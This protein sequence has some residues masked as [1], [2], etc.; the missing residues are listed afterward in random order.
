MEPNSF[1][2]CLVRILFGAGMLDRLGSESAMIGH[3]ALIVTGRSSARKTGLLDKV[4]TMLGASGVTSVVYDKIPENPLTSHAHEGA[5]LVRETGCD[6]VLGVGGGSALDAAK[7]IAFAVKNPG[8]ISDYIFGKPGQ[9]ALPI[10]AVPT[11]AGTGSE[12]DSLAV[13]TNPETCD[14]KSLKSPFVYPALAIVD[15]DLLHTLPIPLLASTGFDA[16]SHCVEAYLSRN[17]SPE[18]KALALRGVGLVTQH[19]PLILSGIASSADWR[20]VSMA[21]TL[22]GIA[23]DFAGVTLPHALEHAASGLLNVRHGEGLAAL[24]PS[25][26]VEMVLAAANRADQTV[27]ALLSERLVLLANTID[28][29][30]QATTPDDFLTALNTWMACI[31]FTPS[32]DDL[33]VT[34]A[35]V[36]E[37]NRITQRTMQYAIGNHPHLVSSDGMERLYHYAIRGETV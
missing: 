28:P 25:I 29:T 7:A 34:P 13:L 22:G 37:L 26:A 23:I 9:G 35:H 14:K 11:T 12:S 17:G 18:V 15:P 10:I 3:R 2:P 20:A 32:L 31:R 4:V 8:P 1:G 24:Y 5:D 16:F 30:I 27:D 19:L 36:P 6:M 21:S 33:G